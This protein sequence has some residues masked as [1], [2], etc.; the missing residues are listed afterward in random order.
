MC[1]TQAPQHCSSGAVANKS[2]N[3]DSGD[4]DAGSVL[5]Q[6]QESVVLYYNIL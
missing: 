3:S 4:V 1:P 5:R 6:Q 2:Q